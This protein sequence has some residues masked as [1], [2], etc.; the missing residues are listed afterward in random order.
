[1][2]GLA[3][4]GCGQ[5]LPCRINIRRVWTYRQVFE[6]Y[7]HDANSFVTLTYNDENLPFMGTL[8]P[9]D[10]RNF[11]KRLRRRVEPRKFR[12]Y[13]VGEYGDETFRPHYHLSIFGLGFLDYPE[14]QAAWSKKG[15]PIGAAPV[16]EFNVETAQYTAGYVVKKM[17]SWHDD[18]LTP[19]L[20]PEFSRK[21]NRPG[22]G[23]DAMPIIAETL[24]QYD[25]A[26]DHVVETGDVPKSLKVGSKEVPLGRY[27]RQRL[28]KSIG[29]T[30]AAINEVKA[31]WSREASEEMCD[32]LLRASAT[33][34]VRNYT[35]R[36]VLEKENLG[37]IRS[38]EARQKLYQPRRM[39]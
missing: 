4:V 36:S 13:A 1:M 32:L 8:S 9:E 21:S 31:R 19:Y 20:H 37:K 14:I 10:L 29:M 16:Y 39:L 18:R 7:C 15:E 12:F 27:L 25:T 28:R 35:A 2:V 22:I 38:L 6:S 3:P 23:A 24:L 34:A 5:C 30:D 26:L 17:T 11:L 33:E